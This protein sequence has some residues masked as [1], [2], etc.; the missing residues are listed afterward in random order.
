M[1]YRNSFSRATFHEGLMDAMSPGSARYPVPRT[2]DDN[3][4][5]Y[6]MRDL[7]QQ[8]SRIMTE[9][10]NSGQ[11]AFITR[12]GRFIAVI[13]PLAPGHVESQVLAEMAREIAEQ[14]QRQ[15]AVAAARPHWSPALPRWT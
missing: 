1:Y 15:A 10:E 6:T 5:V 11:P 8:A 7:N 13:T 3:A 9:I 12:H 4:L 14:E 2:G